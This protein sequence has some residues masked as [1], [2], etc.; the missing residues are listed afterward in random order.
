MPVMLREGLHPDNRS[1][2]RK[3][4]E[5]IVKMRFVKTNKIVRAFI[6]G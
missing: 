2:N 3:I 4:P 6:S 5:K 1:T